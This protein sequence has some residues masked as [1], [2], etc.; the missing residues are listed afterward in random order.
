[1]VARIFEKRGLSLI[2]I[3]DAGADL[4]GQYPD[5][6]RVAVQVHAPVNEKHYRLWWALVNKLV[7]SGAWDQDR[8]AFKDWIL[9]QTKR[10][11]S[12]ADAE[13]GQVFFAGSLSIDAFTDEEWRDWFVLACEVICKKLLARNDHAWLRRELEQEI[14]K[15]NYYRRRG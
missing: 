10:V 5:G 13:T 8:E 11:R 14:E 6:K 9:W 12:I 1:M 3:D 4:L 15:T 2:P 7:K